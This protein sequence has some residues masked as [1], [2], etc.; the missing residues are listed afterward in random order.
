V[1]VL[2]CRYRYGRDGVHWEGVV[3]ALPRQ[4]EAATPKES[5]PSGP[6]GI[7]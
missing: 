7:P 5:G 3:P 6:G 1:E 4:P 2:P